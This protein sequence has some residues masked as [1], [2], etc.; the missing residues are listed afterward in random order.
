MHIRSLPDLQPTPTDSHEGYSYC[1]GNPLPFGASLV[2]GG[3]NFSIYSRNATGCTLVLFEPG[4]LTPL[5]DIPVPQHFRIGDVY[6]IVVLDLDPQNIE[7]GFRLDGPNDPANGLRF[8][9]TQ[10]LLDPYATIISGHEVWG[11]D[12][13]WDN[14][15]RHRAKINYEPFDW[16]FDRP[17][18]RPIEDVVI[19]EMHVR[20]FTQHPSAQVNKPGTFA[21]V[22]DKIPYLKQL[23]VNTVELMPVF[24]FD[25]WEHSKVDP[26]TGQRTM[27]Y[28]GYSPIGFFAPKEAYGSSDQPG[29][30]VNELKALVKE[31]HE[32]GIEVILD[33]VFNHT[34]EGNELGPTISFRGV[35]DRIYYMLT[36][37]GYYYNFSGTGNTFNCNHPRVQQMIMDCLRYW[38]SEYHVDGFRFDLASIMTRDVDGMPLNDPP[39]LRMMTDDPLLGQTKL[40]AEPWDADGLYHLGSFPS[41]GRWAE[42]NGQYRDTMRKFLKGDEGQVGEVAFMLQG[43]PNLYP[44]RGP[45]AS[46]NFITSHDGFTLRDLVSYNEKHNEANLEE[47]RDGHNDNHS[48][49]CGV[50]GSTDDPKIIELRNRQ[51]RNAL[52]MLLVSQGTPMLLM[53]DEIGRTQNGN[54]N[55]YCHDTEMNWLDWTLVKTNRDLLRFVQHLIAFRTAHPVLRNGHFMQHQD[56]LE[57]GLPDMA[58]HGL[59]PYQPN[60]GPQSHVLAFSLGG[61]YAKGGMEA[62]DH[63]Y[64]AMNMHW[65]NKT[66]YLPTL[67]EGQRWHGFVNTGRVRNASVQPGK[68]KPLKKQDRLRMKPRSVVVLVGR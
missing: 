2:T 49:N 26:A 34:A 55:A 29:G 24:E 67:P 1:P 46:I 39:I 6:S 54:N 68:E 50:E 22:R 11:A 45:I 18:C 41:Y 44:G 62:D 37:E 53:G 10:I 35:D 56:Y 57:K 64:V 30:A 61:D 42:W 65:Q 13:K 17:L 51:V 16:G 23:G 66:F 15:Y 38:V 40:I 58:F 27:N 28:W 33:V 52:T 36:P 5:V 7:Y 25:E 19:Y 3:I 12:P 8:D 31:L 59:Q 63:V 48:W 21:G 47:N 9:P 20:G 32:N 60:W 14:V 43:S 4:A